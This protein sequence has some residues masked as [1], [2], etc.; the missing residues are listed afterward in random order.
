MS[1]L[2]ITG[3]A[4]PVCWPS[5]LPSPPPPPP[6]SLWGRV[7]Y[8]IYL[9]S[10]VAHS[11]HRQHA[12]YQHRSIPSHQTELDFLCVSGDT[13]ILYSVRRHRGAQMGLLHSCTNR[14]CYTFFLWWVNIFFKDVRYCC[15]LRIFIHFFSTRNS[16]RAGKFFYTLVHLWLETSYN[17]FSFPPLGLAHSSVLTTG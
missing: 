14:F 4:L 6:Q 10:S 2:Q 8:S 17:I 7:K 13:C 16:W 12:P 1:L 11:C 3:K 5:A 15:G 9:I